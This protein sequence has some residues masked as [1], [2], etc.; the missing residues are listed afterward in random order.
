M[1]RQIFFVVAALLAVTFSRFPA[2][3]QSLTGT[4]A[5]RALDQQ[6]GVL[7]GVTVTLTGKTGSQTQVTDA[8]GEFRFIALS[9]GNYSLKAEL[10]GFREK[11][12][13]TLDL[14]IGNTIELN[15]E[16][17]LSGLSESVQVVANA[18]SIDTATDGD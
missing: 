8:R 7:P 10:Q 1:R 15:L 4:I 11:E 12:E 17:Q 13:P 3:A 6:G 5:G 2:E 18:V 16:M 14:G 9:V